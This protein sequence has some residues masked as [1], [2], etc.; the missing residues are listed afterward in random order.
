M[1]NSSFQKILEFKNKMPLD[2][3]ILI[4][5][6][7]LSRYDFS[8]KHIKGKQNLI[9]GLLSRPG[10]IVQMITTTH[11][12]PLILMVKPLS[13][14]AKTCKVFPPGLTPSSTQDILEYAKTHY[15]YFIHETMK[16]KVIAPFMFNPNN[17][18]GG[19]FETKAAYDIL[20]DPHKEDFLF[21]TLLEWFSPLNW[22]REELRRILVFE[23]GRRIPV[24][25]PYFQYPNGQIWSNNGTFEDYPL[26]ESY[27]LQLS[28][29]LRE[30]NSTG[31]SSQATINPYPFDRL[32]PST[33]NTQ[34]I[35]MFKSTTKYYVPEERFQRA[36]NLSDQA[37]NQL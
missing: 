18:Y 14:K 11:S 7:W 15:F 16:Y 28:Q 22:W 35:K 4:L 2:P 36:E 34:E 6:D 32:I 1:D 26:D 17:P 33:S 24:H 29:H 5:K 9:P 21:W 3:Q 8:V 10:K 13:N 37:D 25:R 20:M 31:T 30:I 27:K 19:V 12:F 23:E